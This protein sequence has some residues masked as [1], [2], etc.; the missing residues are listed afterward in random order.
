MNHHRQYVR[1]TQTY[2][3]Y[4]TLV[5]G[6]RPGLKLLAKKVLGIDI[7]S[8]EHSSVS[9]ITVFNG[10]ISTRERI[11]GALQFCV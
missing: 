5:G 3:G 11:Q 8:G 1:D 6:R 9:P 10:I 2:S 4:R 7:Q